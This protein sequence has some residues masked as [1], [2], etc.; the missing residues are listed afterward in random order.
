MPV[1]LVQGVAQGGPGCHAQL[2][3]ELIQV[4]GDGARGQEQSLADLLVGQA[5]SRQERDFSLLLRD[6]TT[7]DE[8]RKAILSIGIAEITS[9]EAA[10]LFR[11][12]NVPPGKYSLLV[13]VT[14]QSRETTLT[15]AQISD[16]STKV[17]AVL[18]KSLGARLRAS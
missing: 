10:D 7:F 18:E 8:V 6:G 3:E 12:K 11:G 2:R 16:Y 9:I 14:F 13:R 5:R 1:H 17:V 15:D 4:G